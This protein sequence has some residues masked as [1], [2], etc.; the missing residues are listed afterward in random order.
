M[1]SFERSPCGTVYVWGSIFSMMPSA[2]ISAT[3][4][5]RAAKRFMPFNC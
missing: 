5:F 3:M 2:S 1:T 4:R